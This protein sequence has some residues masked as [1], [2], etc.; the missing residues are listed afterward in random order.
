[1]FLANLKI[2]R[3]VF[4]EAADLFIEPDLRRRIAEEIQTAIEADVFDALYGGSETDDERF[5]KA[6][7]VTPSEEKALAVRPK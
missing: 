5:A 2:E 6:R 4:P 3:V 1:M 7:D